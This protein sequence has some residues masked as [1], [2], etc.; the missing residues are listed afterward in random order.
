MNI[1][2]DHAPDLAAAAIV[3]GLLGYALVLTLAAFFSGKEE[4]TGARLSA[5]VTS[6]TAQKSRNTARGTRLI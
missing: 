1:L 2:I 6:A 4:S 3:L 5:W